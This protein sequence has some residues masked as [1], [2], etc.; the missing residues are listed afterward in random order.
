MCKEFGHSQ[1][2]NWPLVF[3]FWDCQLWRD[4]HTRASLMYRMGGFTCCLVNQN[5]HLML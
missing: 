4:L 3:S 1:C 5:D 2:L